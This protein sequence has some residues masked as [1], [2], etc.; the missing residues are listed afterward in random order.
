MLVELSKRPEAPAELEHE[1]GL[2]SHAAER[3]AVLL[4]GFHRVAAGELGARLADDLTVLTAADG[5]QAVAVLEQ[6]RV[7]VLCLG[8]DQGGERAR[9]LLARVA[10]LGAAGAT[11]NVVMAAGPD[12]GLFQELV[13]RDQLFYL[14][15]QPP[16]VGDIELIL[17]SAA[18]RFQAATGTAGGATARDPRSAAA[19]QVLE[20]VR[21][22]GHEAAPARV[23]PLTAREIETLAAADRAA[24]LLY[25]RS[26]ETLWCP[27]P[28]EA[29]ERRES[30]AAGLVGFVART[31]RPVARERVG[32]DPR[33][34]ADADSGDGPPDERFLAVPVLAPA[35]A[36]AAPE[37]RVLAILV[38]LRAASGPPF[39]DDDGC[40]LTYL[41][42]QV[43]PIFDRLVRGSELEARQ[44]SSAEPGLFRAEALEHHH[45]G[46]PD[47]GNVLEISPIWTRWVYR[48]LVAVFAAAVL[49]AVWGTVD[50]YAE[51]IAVVRAEGRS[52]VTAPVAGTV[53]TLEVR[54]GQRVAAGELLVRLYGAQEAAELERVR[55]EFELG[56]LDRLR[57]PADPSAARALGGLRT[58][59]RRAEAHLEERSVRS[60]AAGVV[61]DLRVRPGQLLSPGEVILSLRGEDPELRIVALLPGR[62]RPL[63]RPGMAMRLE[64]EG[65]RYAY[66]QLRVERISDEVFGP[67]ETRRV[68]GPGIGDAVPLA[69][70]VVFVEARLPSPTFESDGRVY[71]Y[72]DGILGRAEVRVRSESLLVTLVPGLKALR[73]GGDG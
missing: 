51:G 32:E 41:A 20:L 59:K 48:L 66:Q 55:R 35:A 64:L 43:A 14:T 28:G 49:Y 71:A 53:S 25:D 15:A 8:E 65:Y 54:P 4:V 42:E 2:A 73:P 17:R 13:D 12:L 10:T 52:D 37:P 16:P 33:Y 5:D 70:P 31:G 1:S 44:Q 46:L 45:R 11:Q 40:R 39:S 18:A 22:L 27:L 34:D 58:Q 67:T 23:L 29:E 9:Q 21:Q 6:R 62:Y 19:P 56:L 30:A 60:P 26:T 36:P 68:L 72:H 50:E 69:G 47:Q 38:A 63:L 57:H 24:C 61:S 3:P 7:A